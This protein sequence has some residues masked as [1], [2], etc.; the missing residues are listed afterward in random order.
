MNV[1]AKEDVQITISKIEK[2]FTI[3]SCD[4]KNIFI[5]L[6]ETEFKDF[7]DKF[8]ELKS[9]QDLISSLYSMIYNNNR[10]ISMTELVD[11]VKLEIVDYY[12]GAIRLGISF[13]FFCSFFLNVFLPHSFG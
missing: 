10:L 7:Y 11:S 1:N 3:F 6:N 9:L 8:I 13:S 4:Q 2:I 5:S 12:K